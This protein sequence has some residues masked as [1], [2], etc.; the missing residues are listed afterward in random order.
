MFHHFDTLSSTNDEARD[1]RYTEGDWLVAE[2][3]TAGRGQ[4]GHSWSSGT[5]LNLTATLLLEPHFIAV[6][7]QFLLSQLAAL[8]LCDL[9]EG[10]GIAPRI[11]WT[12]DLYVG[13][14]KIAG[15]LIEHTL[16]GDRLNRTL[17]GIGLNINQSE[18]DP[19][20]PNPTSMA[21][22][23]GR[24]FPREEVSQ[25]LWECLMA[26]YEQLRGQ[27]SEALQHDY[28]RRIYRLDQTQ[29][30]RLPSGA[31]FV[32]MIR[33]VA[34]TGELMV[35]HPDGQTRAYLFREIEFVIAPEGVTE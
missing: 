26:R 19:L 3:Q 11:K 12:N 24:K 8:A 9:L 13:D 2:R 15:I 22:V 21:R 31:E 35:E 6:R 29:R 14:R 23:C 4:R 1:R 18:F 30:F 17:V 20:L 28:H 32:G 7:E 25:R 34:P 27:G 16:C 10:Y 33:D 5:G